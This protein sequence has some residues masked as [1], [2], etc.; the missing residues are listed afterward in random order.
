[1]DIFDHQNH[2]DY[3]R[4]YLGG[5]KAGG[6]R[7]LAQKAGFKSPGHITMLVKGERRLT[8]ESAS[9]LISGLGLRGRKRAM[10]CSLS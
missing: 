2:R 1:M 9:K 3:L 10:I 5:K 7:G 4:A 8:S 6:L